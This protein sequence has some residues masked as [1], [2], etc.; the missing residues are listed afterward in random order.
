M[1][2]HYCV[3]TQDPQFVAVLEFLNH[4]AIKRELHLNRTHFWIDDTAPLHSLLLLG[5]AASIVCIE[6]EV[7]HALGV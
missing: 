7:D 6:H 4:H 5:Y 2:R 3:Y 1:I